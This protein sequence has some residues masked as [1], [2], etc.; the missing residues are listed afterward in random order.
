MLVSWRVCANPQKLWVEPPTYEYNLSTSVLVTAHVS[1]GLKKGKHVNNQPTSHFRSNPK[2]IVLANFEDFPMKSQLIIIYSLVSLREHPP[3]SPSSHPGVVA[4][5]TTPPLLQLILDPFL[6]S[7]LHFLQPIPA[8]NERPV[9]F[10]TVSRE[11]FQRLIRGQH[12][13]VGGF[14]SSE[15][16]ESQLGL[17]FPIWKNK[18]CSKPP[19]SDNRWDLKFP[20]FPKFETVT[21]KWYFL[22]CSI[23]IYSLST[24][25]VDVLNGPCF[26]SLVEA[27]IYSKP[28]FLSTLW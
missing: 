11:W 2:L 7:L 23:Y 19:I 18:N 8:V 17:L 13:L 10:L 5:P 4:G 14:N 15:K 22:I 16:Y 21:E 1:S 27:N 6:L 9:C 24:R 12:I 20:R 25:K 28:A 26:T 3:S